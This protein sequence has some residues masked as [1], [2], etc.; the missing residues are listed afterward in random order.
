MK[1]N[2]YLDKTLLVKTCQIHKEFKIDLHP[3]DIQ[4][5]NGIYKKKD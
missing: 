3:T 1:E 2:F 5:I 4:L